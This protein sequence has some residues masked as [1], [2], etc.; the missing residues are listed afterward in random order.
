M[1]PLEENN[2]TLPSHPVFAFGFVWR[3]DL[4]A[5]ENAVAPGCLLPN[6]H[7]MSL[8]MTDS[9]S[10]LAYHVLNSNPNKVLGSLVAGRPTQEI[11]GNFSI[12]VVEYAG[13]RQWVD[14]VLPSDLHRALLRVA[15]MERRYG[16]VKIALDPYIEA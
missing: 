5:A 10:G 8:F 11:T 7:L 14:D 16:P 12:N 2:L 13:I 1:L 3:A 6:L 15:L 9:R 4:E